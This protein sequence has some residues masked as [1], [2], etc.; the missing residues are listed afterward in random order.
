MRILF[1][2]LGLAVVASHALAQPAPANPEDQL[3]NF[4]FAHEL[5]SGIYAVDGRTVQIYRI[6]GSYEVFEPGKRPFGLTVR[7]PATL[8]FF[9]FKPEDVL[10]LDLPTH[11]GAASLVPGL[12]FNVPL[13]ERWRVEPFAQVGAAKDFEGGAFSWVWSLGVLNE[14]RYP[15]RGFDWRLAN[16]VVWAGAAAANTPTTSYVEIKTGVEGGRTFR[17]APREGRHEPDFTF[18][19]VNFLYPS[20]I[21]LFGGE[22]SGLPFESSLQWETGVTFGSRPKYHLWKIPLPRIG[23]GFRFGQ[24]L[25][26]VRLVFGVPF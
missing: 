19:L 6:P 26:A 15:E 5:G 21:D 14:Y 3:L 8:G 11:I 2:A 17:K 20:S 22:G 24:D 13:S 18:Y 4:A 16:R 7:F 1:V 10:N 23:L 9:D 25:T 12:S